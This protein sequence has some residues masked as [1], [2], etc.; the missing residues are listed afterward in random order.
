M[1]RKPKKSLVIILC[2]SLFEILLLMTAFGP[3]LDRHVAPLRYFV[4][5]DT[6]AVFMAGFVLV[7]VVG[8]NRFTAYRERRKAARR[9]PPRLYSSG[10]WWE[11]SS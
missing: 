2:A 5:A 10:W 1:F 9:P 7:F 11:K 4:D 6:A 8:S 3:W